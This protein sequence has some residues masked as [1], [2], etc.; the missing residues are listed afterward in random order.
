[1]Q[2]WGHRSLSVSKTYSAVET[3]ECRQP[4]E[5]LS[6]EQ[7]HK[8]S[9]TCCRYSTNVPLVATLPAWCWNLGNKKEHMIVDMHINVLIIFG[10]QHELFMRC[11]SMSLSA[12]ALETMWKNGWMN[13]CVWIAWVSHASFLAALCPRHVNCILGQLGKACFTK[14]VILGYY[15]FLL[16]GKLKQKFTKT[17]IFLKRHPINMFNVCLLRFFNLLIQLLCESRHLVLLS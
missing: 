5:P 9:Q 15:V 16:L 2:L 8:H 17:F 6:R 14:F 10:L 1:M 13:C 7:K 12:M 4:A 3:T 11:P